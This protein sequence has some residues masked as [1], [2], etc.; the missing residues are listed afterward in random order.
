MLASA[1][2]R[3]GASQG[4]PEQSSIVLD[5]AG[6][7]RQLDSDHALRLRDAAADRAGRSS[8]ARDLSLLV[9]FTV[10]ASLHR[11]AGRLKVLR[12][13]RSALAC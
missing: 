2:L 7:R 10:A 13:W 4:T 12:T 11:T 9:R 5:V 8:T 3:A 1:A 6:A